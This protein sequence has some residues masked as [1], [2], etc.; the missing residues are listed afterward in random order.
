M[1]LDTTGSDATPQVTLPQAIS[2][3]VIVSQSRCRAAGPDVLGGSVTNPTT[4]TG[5]APSPVTVVGVE[6]EDGDAETLGAD[7][8]VFS[9]LVHG[10]GQ[11]QILR[12]RLL[13]GFCS[14]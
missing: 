9:G 5:Q 6:I 2:G 1:T 3:D 12:P 4:P 8:Q 11:M 10:A 14:P 13:L 7:L